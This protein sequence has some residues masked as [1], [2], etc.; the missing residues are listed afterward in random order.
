MDNFFPMFGGF[1]PLVGRIP[2]AYPSPVQQQQAVTPEL[3]N[4]KEDKKEVEK[5]PE[6]RSAPKKVPD[7]QVGFQ[8]RALDAPIFHQAA[9]IFGLV[10]GDL[11]PVD[12]NKLQGLIELAAEKLGTID[13]TKILSFIR[14][15]SHKY[16]GE[17][18]FREMHMILCMGQKP[19][20]RKS[21]WGK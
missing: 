8:G 1:P 19:T 12:R 6:K 3:V 20:V 14:R 21:P 9:D 17:N 11:A 4:E 18:R 13:T 7:I 2:L 5:K 16:P 15:E 10:P